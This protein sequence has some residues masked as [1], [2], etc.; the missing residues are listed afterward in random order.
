MR[1]LRLRLRLRL[2]SGSRCC[3][4]ATLRVRSRCC[5]RHAFRNTCPQIHDPLM[6]GYLLDLDDCEL[7]LGQDALDHEVTPRR[8]QHLSL[9]A[10]KRVA[11][12]LTR[13]ALRELN[14]EDGPGPA[15]SAEERVPEYFDSLGR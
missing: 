6:R 12:D 4:S 1:W 10:H 13:L 3:P 5:W 7:P 14:G 2:M 8:Q 9:R 11:G 15:F